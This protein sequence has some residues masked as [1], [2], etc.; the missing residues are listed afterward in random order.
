MTSTRE[1]GLHNVLAT[2]LNKMDDHVKWLLESHVNHV[3][4]LNHR[5]VVRFHAQGTN[6]HS[7]HL[8]VEVHQTTRSLFYLFLQ[9]IDLCG[10]LP[11]EALEPDRVFCFSWTTL[12]FP[13]PRLEFCTIPD[14]AVPDAI[15]TQMLCTQTESWVCHSFLSHTHLA[16]VL[17]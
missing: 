8:L 12:Q 5:H 10:P 15:S 4:V 3:A 14:V 16:S 7:I 2:L 1:C 6:M 9:V 11:S 17:W 13:K